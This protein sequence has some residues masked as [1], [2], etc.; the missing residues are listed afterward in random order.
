MNGFRQD[1]CEQSDQGKPMNSRPALF[2]AEY[3]QQCWV[4]KDEGGKGGDRCNLGCG[5]FMALLN[6]AIHEIEIAEDQLP[7]G[8]RGWSF[9]T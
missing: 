1:V 5:D 6:G 8:Q 3:R 4:G 9:G 7:S 2:G